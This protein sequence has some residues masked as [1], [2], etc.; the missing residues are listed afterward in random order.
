MSEDE[1][2]FFRK[3]VVHNNAVQVGWYLK[4]AAVRLRHG[5]KCIR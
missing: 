5:R 3:I 4:G 2:K 1:M